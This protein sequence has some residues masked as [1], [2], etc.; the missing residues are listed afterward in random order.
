MQHSNQ[1]LVGTYDGVKRKRDIL[2]KLQ[3]GFQR[4]QAMNLHQQGQQPQPRAD[5]PQN[6]DTIF[7][8]LLDD[9]ERLQMD[10]LKHTSSHATTQYRSLQERCVKL[11]MALDNL[12]VKGRE[13]LR[14]KR[15]TVL[16]NVNLVSKNLSENT[17]SH[18]Q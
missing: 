8:A 11:E 6:A 17:H 5:V 4:I 7:Q 12:N 3:P 18:A 16:I 9:F 2:G 1:L 15:K 14:N 10:A 13:D